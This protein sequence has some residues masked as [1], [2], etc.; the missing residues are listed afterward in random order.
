MPRCDDTLWIASWSRGTDTRSDGVLAL[1]TDD[2]V[3][4]VTRG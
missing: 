4:E 3:W 1:I 2:C